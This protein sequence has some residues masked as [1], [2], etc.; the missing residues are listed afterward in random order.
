MLL[1]MRKVRYSDVM[2]GVLLGN[3]KSRYL[4]TYLIGV[5]DL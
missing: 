2:C 5:G 3:D 4:S 1:R